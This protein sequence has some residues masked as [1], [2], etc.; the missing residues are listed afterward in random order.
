MG[1]IN[2]KLLSELVIDTFVN[3]A[4]YSS[5]SRYQKGFERL[6]LILP[7]GS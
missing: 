3:P 1:A 4:R 2:P 7:S 5:I 6:A